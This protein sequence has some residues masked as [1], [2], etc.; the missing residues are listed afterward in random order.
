[1][2]LAAGRGIVS[3]ALFP[4][5]LIVPNRYDTP[6]GCQRGAGDYPWC[7]RWGLRTCV[8]MPSVAGI[9]NIGWP[10]D[11]AAAA[12]GKGESVNWPVVKGV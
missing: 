3:S 7:Y 9:G 1:M 10:G 2:R 11:N 4:I 6:I 12:I 8:E 5:D